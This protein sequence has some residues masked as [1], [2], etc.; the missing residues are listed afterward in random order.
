IGG[1]LGG[2]VWI[3]HVYDGHNKTFFFVNYDRTLTN[4]P[5]LL[6]LTVPTAVQRTGDLSNALATTDANGNPRKPQTI[7]QPTGVASPAFAGDQVGPIDPAAAKI[8]ALLPLPNTLGT[9]DATN[10]R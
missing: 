6:S 4:T 8:L 3:P 1:S 5:T 2:P 9:Y 7:Y 10:N